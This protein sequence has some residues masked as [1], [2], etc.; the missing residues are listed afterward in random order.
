MNHVLRKFCGRRQNDFIPLI[1]EKRGQLYLRAF[2]SFDLL[3]IAGVSLDSWWMLILIF[4]PEVGKIRAAGMTL[5]NHDNR[6]PFYCI[7]N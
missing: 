4:C 1:R 3:I 7:V 6:L 2:A 5:F